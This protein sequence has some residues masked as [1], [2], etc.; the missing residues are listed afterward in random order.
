MVEMVEMALGQ[1][2]MQV[3]CIFVDSVITGVG[4]A[5]HSLKS[6]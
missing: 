3:L 1:L 5:Q 2:K 4:I 6:I